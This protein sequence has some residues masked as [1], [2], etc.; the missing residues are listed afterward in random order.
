M[1]YRS[2]DRDQYTRPEEDNKTCAKNMHKSL[3]LNN[4]LK[5]FHQ[6]KV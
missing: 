6:F 2:I 1:K 5:G 3:R 4:D